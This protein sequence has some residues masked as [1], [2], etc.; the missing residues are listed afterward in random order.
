[1][2]IV[3]A[4]VN[5]AGQPILLTRQLQKM[6]VDARLVQ[7]L[8]GSAKA[9]KFGYETDEVVMMTPATRPEVQLTTL[10]RLLDDGTDIFHFWLRSMVYGRPYRDLQGL[11][12][13]II[14]AHGRKVVYRFTGFDLRLKS[15]HMKVNPYNPFQYGYDHGMNEEAQRS[16]LE[17]LR[18]YVDTFIVQ[19]AEMGEFMPGASVLPR[20]MD[21]SHW[22]PVGVDP[23]KTRPLVIHS[24]S[25]TQVKGTSFVLAAVEKLKQEGLS[26]DFKLIENMKHADA[27]ELYK[28][29]DIAIDQLLIGWY[30]VF[31]LE[32]MALAKPTIV[33]VREEPLRR[34]GLDVPIQNANPDTI[35]DRLRELIVDGQLRKELG[36]RGREF[37]EREHA[38]EMVAEKALALYSRVHDGAG[39][40]RRDQLPAAPALGYIAAQVMDRQNEVVQGVKA[41]KH[42]A[43]THRRA[44]AGERLAAKNRK[45]LNVLQERLIHTR[46][47]LAQAQEALAV[48]TEQQT[49]EAQKLAKT[50]GELRVASQEL[51]IEQKARAEAERRVA[52]LGK[53]LTTERRD[54]E[55]LGAENARLTQERTAADRAR[56]NAGLPRKA[57][58]KYF[59]E[60]A[61]GLMRSAQ[62][63]LGGR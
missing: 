7:F 40:D 52:S 3:M 54:G 22:E 13:P 43:E 17:Y 8:Q 57:A 58:L 59:N 42:L 32:A 47:K 28:Q 53:A 27:I 19:D 2:K 61:S 10:G 46:K 29:C 62:R 30:G 15:D 41:R 51:A 36:E 50:E 56:R 45:G 44:L 20:S 39:N 18:R 26:F 35:V 21:L 37:V 4:P 1:M 5:I 14:K 24:P 49:A 12:L 16:Y 25:K 34:S 48:S 33:Y 63:R 6:G 11:D 23:T 60:G 31:S 38:V 55:Q 9:N